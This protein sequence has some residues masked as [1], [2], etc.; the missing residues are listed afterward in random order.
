MHQLA[1]VPFL[2]GHLPGADED[3]QQVP[4]IASIKSQL[5]GLLIKRRHRN[6][7]NM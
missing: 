3:A 4:G 2:W 5:W 6:T 7:L 1:V